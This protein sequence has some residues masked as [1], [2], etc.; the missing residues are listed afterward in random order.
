MPKTIEGRDASYLEWVETYFHENQKGQRDGR[1]LREAIPNHLSIEDV[2]D[3]D[4]FDPWRE[5]G[6]AQEREA[7]DPEDKAEYDTQRDF[8]R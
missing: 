1:D 4:D 6:A 5:E 7:P 8:L 3:D 2:Y